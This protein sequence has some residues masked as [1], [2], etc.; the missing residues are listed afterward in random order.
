MMMIN[1]F[2]DMVDRWKVFSLIS[3]RDHCHR[4]SPSR[5]SDKPRAGFEPAQNLSSGLVEWSCAVVITTTPWRHKNQRHANTKHICS[6]LKCASLENQ[7]SN[8]FYYQTFNYLR[9]MWTVSLRLWQ[10]MKFWFS[11]DCSQ[12]LESTF[13]QLSTWTFSLTCPRNQQIFPKNPS[14]M[15]IIKSTNDTEHC[16]LLETE[17]Y[18][19]KNQT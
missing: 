8:Y 15:M 10:L 13:E 9:T 14:K 6:T 17:H 7:P 3:S 19:A 18:P 12:I 1:W 2:C 4:S 16:Y 5:I 11:H